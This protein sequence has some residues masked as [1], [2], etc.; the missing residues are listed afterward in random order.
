[1]EQNSPYGISDERKESFF[2][3]SKILDAVYDMKIPTNFT[4]QN[5]NT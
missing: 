5:N 3:Q 4:T 1:M 2:K